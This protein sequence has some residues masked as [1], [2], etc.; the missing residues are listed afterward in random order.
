[1][2]RPTDPGSE[3]QARARVRLMQESRWAESVLRTV[4]GT[5]LKAASWRAWEDQTAI[6]LPDE[7]GEWKLGIY[8]PDMDLEDPNAWSYAE[9]EAE[10]RQSKPWKWETRDHLDLVEDLVERLAE[11]LEHSPLL[12]PDFLLKYSRRAGDMLTARQ[13]PITTLGGGYQSLWKAPLHPLGIPP[14]D[15]PASPERD[16][17]LK[18]VLAQVSFEAA[19]ELYRSIGKP[20]P[21]ARGRQGLER[22][23]V[24]RQWLER[25]EL[26][27]PDG[28]LLVGPLGDEEARR[29]ATGLPWSKAQATLLSPRLE[30]QGPDRPPGQLHRPR[31]GDSF[32]AL[33]S[34]ADHDSAVSVD[35][36]AW[37]HLEKAQQLLEKHG[38]EMARLSLYFSMR[39]CELSDP[40]QPFLISGTDLLQDFN[41]ASTSGGRDRQAMQVRSDRLKHQAEMA[42]HLERIVVESTDYTGQVDKQGRRQFRRFRGRV[43]TVD[44]LELGW[45]PQQPPL[46][47]LTEQPEEV[48]TDLRMLVRAGAW[49]KDYLNPGVQGGLWYAE[50]ATKV[51]KLSHSKNQLAACLGLYLSTALNERKAQNQGEARF[52]VATL[53]SKVLTPAELQRAKEERGA[54]DLLRN[55]WVAALEL[56][57]RVVE[58]RFAFCPDTY[59]VW[60]IP[61]VLRPDGL[62]VPDR[63]PHRAL[64]QLLKGY[65]T[66]RWPAPVLEANTTSKA[67]AERR[68]KVAEIKAAPIRKPVIPS[69]SHGKT[70]GDTLREAR[71]ATGF[72][73]RTAAE[74]LG[75]S[76]TL[77][78]FYERNSRPL[79]LN[80]LNRYLELLHQAYQRER[81]QRTQSLIENKLS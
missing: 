76:Q 41:L 63:A 3:R 54:S 42:R 10:R 74:V 34:V 21:D 69:P 77:M 13:L 44:S 40:S 80:D 75:I 22:P 71:K 8:G 18:V 28:T 39:V 45:E 55:R 32:Q 59:P 49:V 67:E 50:V 2:P 60:A 35:P 15:H 56:L 79:K 25:L 51:L 38:P 58:F 14:E 1:M 37:A 46:G 24:L 36:L 12:G 64:D 52:V 57:H 27:E 43:W 70:N 16:A 4:A 66:I 72:N 29:A 19:R 61:E 6:T 31:Q 17:E 48:V 26:I 30:E 81:L 20:E 47:D 62:T 7:P 78:S 9:R 23:E 65:I 33:V 5:L 11:S 73:Q 53:L 68:A